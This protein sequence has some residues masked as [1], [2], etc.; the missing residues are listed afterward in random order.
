M[1]DAVDQLVA[2][3]SSS[4]RHL[5]LNLHPWLIGQPFRI[6]FLDDALGHLDRAG[7]WKATGS[8]IIES[9]SGQ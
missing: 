8:E 6:G 1:G 3:S 5:V 7:V 9:F 4:G 2:D